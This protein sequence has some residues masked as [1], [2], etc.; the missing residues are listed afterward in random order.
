MR[1]V[2]GAVT[3]FATHIGLE[4]THDDAEVSSFD[5]N[6]LLLLDPGSLGLPSLLGRDML[7]RG[8]L[9]FDPVGG[10]VSLDLPKGP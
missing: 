10:R 6:V 9:H 4:F 1:G 3:G 8:P 7:F 2:G 5:L